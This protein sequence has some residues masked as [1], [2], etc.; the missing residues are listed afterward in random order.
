[1]LASVFLLPDE[2]IFWGSMTSGS[3]LGIQILGWAAVSV[4]T[5]VLTWVYF[6][7]LKR[8]RILK[9]KQ[10]QEILGL[11]AVMQAQS[12]RVEIKSL[13]KAIQDAYPEHRKRGC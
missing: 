8:C 6:F 5:T 10:S 4:W 9:V 7:S 3:L 13:K 12:T 1:M 11:D 2:G